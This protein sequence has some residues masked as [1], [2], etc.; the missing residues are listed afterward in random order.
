MCIYIYIHKHLAPTLFGDVEAATWAAT[1]GGRTGGGERHRA[2]SERAFRE[3][4]VI[5]IVMTTTTTTTTA[6]TTTTT[7][8]TTNN[9]NNNNNTAS[10]GEV[11][12]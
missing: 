6:T 9:N 5:V 10:R 8:T 11:F 4:I 3:V 1:P 2:L 7:T 12:L